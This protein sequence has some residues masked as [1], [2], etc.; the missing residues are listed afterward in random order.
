MGWLLRRAVRLGE[1]I[2]LHIRASVYDIYMNSSRIN[3]IFLWKAFSSTK[4]VYF[5]SL[6]LILLFAISVME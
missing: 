4:S 5:T 3:F 2:C 6:I 1:N